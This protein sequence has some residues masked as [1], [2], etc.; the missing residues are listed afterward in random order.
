VPC[1]C[2]YLQRAAD[3]PIRPIVFDPTTNEYQF[4]YRDEDGRII[5]TLIIYHCPY[6]GGAAP[7]SKRE[8]LFALI[9]PDEEARL[10]SLM[11]PIE[12][13]NDALTTLGAPDFDDYC[14][15]SYP[16]DGDTPPV[17]LYRRLIRYYRLSKIADVAI[18]ERSDGK[19]NWQLEGKFLATIKGRT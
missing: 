5:G 7:K 12:T 13:M 9:P 14:V 8:L 16:E 17:T 15:S 6:C 3:D 2:D 18:T 4:Q 11:A 1:T 19:V 10:A